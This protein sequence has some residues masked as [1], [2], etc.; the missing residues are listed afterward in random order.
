MEIY[1]NSINK[2]Q[3]FVRGGGIVP[4]EEKDNSTSNI[5]PSDISSFKLYED[6]N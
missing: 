3:I 5:F 6:V 1:L 2:I 4:T